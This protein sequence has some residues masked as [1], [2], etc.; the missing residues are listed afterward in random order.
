MLF[1]EKII[2][3]LKTAEGLYYRLV[4]LVGEAN[5]GKTLYLRELANERNLE[6][7]NINLALSKEL[8]EL[9]TKQRTLAL[10]ERLAQ[11]TEASKPFMIL[12]NLEILFD[13]HLQQDALKLVQ[14]L[15]RNSTVIASWNGKI[16]GDKLIY[17]E[18]G[19]PEYQSYQLKD[20]LIVDLN[21]A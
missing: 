1:K 7:L 10:P 17:A 12:D 16:N 20:L 9:S 11:I 14:S 6:V 2:E 15:S 5:S 8:L 4:L 3:T 13:K 19:H 21:N 18:P